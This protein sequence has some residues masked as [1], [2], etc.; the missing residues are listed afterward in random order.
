[1]S[2]CKEKTPSVKCLHIVS[3]CYCQYAIN[4]GSLCFQQCLVISNSSIIHTPSLVA[5]ILKG[6]HML[7]L[8]SQ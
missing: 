6:E 8:G 7:A 2:P 5:K 1:M 4:I 3:H